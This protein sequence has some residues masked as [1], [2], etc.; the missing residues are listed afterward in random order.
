MKVSLERNVTLEVRLS[1]KEAMIL[2]GMLQN[3]MYD[4]LD[5]EPKDE[6]AVRCEL[7]ENLR[8]QLKLRHLP[9]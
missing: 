6:S 3:P 2:M 9:E 1:E 4:S 5:D 8:D 7:F